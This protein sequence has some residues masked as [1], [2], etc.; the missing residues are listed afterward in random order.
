[1]VLWITPSEGSG[2]ELMLDGT[3]VS[4]S[5]EGSQA[6][7]RPKRHL[8]RPQ[9]DSDISCGNKMEPNLILRREIT[10]RN[11]RSPCHGAF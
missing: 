7:R 4:G 10:S 6:L 11:R 5:H 3:G 8:H 9:S 2:F 1:M